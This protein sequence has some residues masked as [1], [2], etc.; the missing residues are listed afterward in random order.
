MSFHSLKKSLLALTKFPFFI[1]S[2]FSQCGDIFYYQHFFSLCFIVLHGDNDL[3]CNFIEVALFIFIRFVVT[4]L[5]I[6]M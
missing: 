2:C 5:C 1:P 6:G 3:Y 4:S